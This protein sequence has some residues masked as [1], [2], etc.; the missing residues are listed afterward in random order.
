MVNGSPLALCS[1]E[2]PLG[3]GNQPHQASQGGSCSRQYGRVSLNLIRPFHRCHPC[4]A[5]P[6]LNT[7]TQLTA[8]G[9]G[10]TGPVAGHLRF[11]CLVNAP[12]LRSRLRDPRPCRSY[13]KTVQRVLCALINVDA[14]HMIV[15]VTDHAFAL[16]AKHALVCF[17]GEKIAFTKYES[18]GNC[19]NPAE[20]WELIA[21]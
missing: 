3:S 18:L 5:Q 9:N 1:P 16:T 12:L 7:A 10:K 8:G 17:C 6:A 4:N 19:T 13:C 11:V 20:H 14:W 2:H 21:L 15:H